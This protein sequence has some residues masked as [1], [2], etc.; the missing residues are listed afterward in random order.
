MADFRSMYDSSWI[1]AFDLKGRD[2]TV[3][4]KEV[5][6]AKIENGRERGEKKTQR[7]PVLFFKESKDQRGLV[8]CKTN[9]KTIAAMYGNDTDAWIGKRVTLFP[10]VTDAFG[11]SNVE[12][13]RIR[14]KAPDKAKAPGEFADVPEMPAPESPEHAEMEERSLDLGTGT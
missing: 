13:I 1:Y 14:P 11:Q 8:L 6:A 12:C 2:V 4:I 7:K 9:G 10:T 3:T 5:R